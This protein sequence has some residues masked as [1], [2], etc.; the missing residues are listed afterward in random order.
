[1]IDNHGPDHTPLLEPERPRKRKRFPHRFYIQY[2]TSGGSWRTPTD[3]ERANPDNAR[4]VFD[5]KVKHYPDKCW[6]VLFNG[7]VLVDYKGER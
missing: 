5:F 1:M 6:R 2:Q 4:R 7:N 3:C